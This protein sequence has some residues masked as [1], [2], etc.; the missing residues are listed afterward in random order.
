[1][2]TDK[3]VELIASACDRRGVPDAKFPDN[4]GEYWALCPFHADT[5]PTSFSFSERGFKCLACGAQGGL[6]ALAE[7]LSVDMPKDPPPSCTLADYAAAKHLSVPYLRGLGVTEHVY[8]GRAEIRIPYMDQDEKVLRVKR[9]L[10]LGK[11]KGMRFTWAKSQDTAMYLYGLWK[12]AEFKLGGWVILVEGESD[13]HTAWL[14]NLPVLG[15][16]GANTWSSD[17]AP[18]LEGMQVYA[19]MEADQGGKAFVERIAQD[20]PGLMILKSPDPMA[21]DLSDLHVSGADVAAAVEEAKSSCVGAREAVDAA[22]KAAETSALSGITKLSDFKIRWSAMLKDKELGDWRDQVDAIAATLTAWLLDK[23]RL[24][25]DVGQDA[26]QGGRPYGVGEDNTIFPIEAD[27][28]PME[29]MMFETGLNPKERA[30]AAVLKALQL[31]A[32][33]KG[34]RIKLARWQYSPPSP[35]GTPVVV[36]VSSG[37]TR[38]VKA[39]TAGLE[40]V[41]NG[42]DDVWFASESCYP[43]WSPAEPVCPTDVSAFK[44]VLQAPPEV[45]NYTPEVQRALLLSWIGSF[46]S[47][48]RPT[49]A[50]VAMGDKGGGK[51]TVVRA[52][53]QMFMGAGA[54]LTSLTDDRKDFDTLV[55]TMSLLALDNVDSTV[56]KWVPD[57]IA[58]AVTGMH[59]EMRA[60]YTN[61]QR[62]TRPVTAVLAITS[63]TG[64]FM[65]ADIAERCLPLTTGVFTD[66]ARMS[67]DEMKREVEEKRNGLLSWAAAAACE[68]LTHRHEAPAGLPL[69][70]TDFA[71]MTWAY[72]RSIRRHDWGATIVLALRHAQTLTMGE[73]DP[74]TE[75]MVGYFDAMEPTGYWK[76]TASELVKDLVAA[77]ADIP[78]FGGGKA[79]ARHIREA[80][81]PLSQAG[82][83]MWITKEG[84]NTTFTVIHNKG[85]APVGILP[86]SPPPRPLLPPIE[87]AL[88]NLRTKD[89]MDF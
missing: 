69:R 43:A 17:W 22:S 35:F 68:M 71:N 83:S 82:F 25:V 7:K 64:A 85:G 31:T 52:V 41:L 77:G 49:P 16:P 72:C 23:G 27:C 11:T 13:C 38:M 48:L 81:A 39:T 32:L 42:T 70:F 66:E 84:S 61:A 75:A 10:A 79:I 33:S 29:L 80:Q 30:Y 36:Y 3:L 86:D 67:D 15:V 1:M 58:S 5:N 87:E 54:E 8:G 51:S 46:V 4:R 12:L 57:K 45:P 55:T 20:L 37:P 19:W 78:F 47:G 60:L 53:V 14:H 34:R 21:K 50:L 88:A 2:E 18:L 76:G 56:E 59:V 6:K 44:C 73:N 74:I 40:L 63:R 65:R 26:S 62:I 24:L 28:V 89:L 9:R